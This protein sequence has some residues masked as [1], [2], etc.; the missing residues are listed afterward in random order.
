MRLTLEQ[1]REIAVG[2]ISVTQENNGIHFAKFTEKQIAA[3][4]ELRQ[5]LGERSNC[6]AGVRL[7]FHTNSHK[8]A[9]SASAGNKFEL[10]IN[11][12]FRKQFL[13]NAVR[14]NNKHAEI[15]LTDALGESLDQV[16]VTLYF[17]AHEVGVLEWM[18]LDDGATVTP[19]RFDR[20]ILFVGDSITQGWAASYDSL[21]YANRTSLF[22]N[23]ESVIQGICGAYFHESTF[24][25]INFDPDWVI[26]AY[27]TNDFGKHS[28]FEELRAHA[29]TYLGLI[30]KEY[31]GKRLL[32][33]SP[34]WRERQEKPMGSFRECREA[35]IDEAIKAGFSHIDGLTL[36]PN[37]P[38]FF[39]DG[40]HPD[41]LGFSFY[42]ESLCRQLIKE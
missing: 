40:L 37:D 21:S 28:T 4:F 38:A 9:F 36:V 17:P 10:Y 6:T 29:S 34:I 18:E 33:I 15:A 35:L 7:D 41:N 30:A 12:M 31:C 1:I 14:E 16:R 32:Y 3:W 42:A 13:M 19:H 25:R 27:G 24:D 11:G 22:F 8:L 26:V 2:A 39:T 20:K 5:D 23:A